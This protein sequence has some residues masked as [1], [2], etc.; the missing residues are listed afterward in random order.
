MAEKRIV[1][2]D[3]G[4]ST[5]VVRAK[6]YSVTGQVWKSSDR[7]VTATRNVTFNNG[8]VM[9]PT[10]VQKLKDGS[11]YFGYDAGVN[12]KGAVLYQNFKVELKDEA[13]ENA[14]ALTEEFISYLGKSYREQR[15]GGYM[16]DVNAEE[17]T[18]I[19]YPVKWD[20]D[21]REFMINASKKAGFKNVEGMDEAQAAIIAVTAL[22]R[23][24]LEKKQYITPGEPVNIMLIDMGAGTTDIVICRYIHGETSTNEVLCTWP[25]EGD[26][27]FGGREMDGILK[28]YITEKVPEEH[29]AMFSSWINDMEY[30]VWK[31]ANVSDT[32][33]KNG[34]VTTFDSGEFILE[35]LGAEM[36]PFTLDRNEFESCAKEYLEKFAELVNGSIEQ[37]VKDGTLRSGNDIDLVILTGGHSQWY[38][39]REMLLGK[40]IGRAVSLEKIKA[41][42]DRIIDISKP[43]ETVALGLVYSKLQV[44]IKK[45]EEIKQQE[46][47][48]K[49]ARTEPKEPQQADTRSDSAWDE[50]Q[51]TLARFFAGKESAKCTYCS[52]YELKNRLHIDKAP[53]QFMYYFKEYKDGTSFAVC[54]DG[55]RTFYW[56]DAEAKFVS[57]QEFFIYGVTKKTGMFKD[58]AY[59]GRGAR[60]FISAWG[61]YGDHFFFIELKNELEKTAYYKQL[62]PQ[63]K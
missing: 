33:A 53:D 39:V 29:R 41:E 3:F 55:I 54:K 35:K 61:G 32:L 48:K 2:I 13:S 58:S 1:G 15:D 44:K 37:C 43:Q 45:P 26:I 57:W 23:D 49:P 10:L 5:S 27:L 20:K 42:P 52:I 47:I 63:W 40:A 28:S 30:K 56:S 8:A 60:I 6:N 46:E 9:V 18:I 12:K 17:K 14:K 38:F 7:D 59:I 34:S 36:E 31:E 25:T 19:S 22:S 50:F 24:M 62:M 51:E 16:G 21:T 11:T 4:T